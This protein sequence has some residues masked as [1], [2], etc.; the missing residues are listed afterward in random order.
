MVRQGISL[1]VRLSG[2][3]VHDSGMLA[4]LLAAVPAIRGKRGYPKHRPAKLHADKGYDYRRCCAAY[5]RRGIRH[6]SPQGC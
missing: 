3:N 4:P 5:T 6:R 1:T 2:A